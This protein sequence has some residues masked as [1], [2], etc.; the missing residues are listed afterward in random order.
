SPRTPGPSALLRAGGAHG[1]GG[2][3]FDVVV[4]R[5]A[6]DRGDRHGQAAGLPVDGEGA[7]EHRADLALQVVGAVDLV[8]GLSELAL[9]RLGDR[10]LQIGLL[11]RGRGRADAHRATG[12]SEAGESDDS[13]ETNLHG[14]TTFLAGSA[15]PRWPRGKSSR[16][17][18]RLGRAV[19]GPG[20]IPGQCFLIR[21]RYAEFCRSRRPQASLRGPSAKRLGSGPIRPRAYR[22]SAEAGEA[23]TGSKA[24]SR[25]CG[26]SSN[27]AEMRCVSSISAAL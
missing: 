3:E 11:D 25:I 24:S 6:L 5:I 20:R 9:Q 7:V 8:G 12:E 27:S 17:S 18:G 21:A 2:L 10:A 26:R 1:S 13:G 23:S 14:F 15:R 19:N 4:D 16:R 22:I